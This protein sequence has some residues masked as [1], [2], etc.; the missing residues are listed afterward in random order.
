MEPERPGYTRAVDVWAVGCVAVVLLTGGLA[1]CDPVT[2]LYSE[3]LA[4][5]CD[6]EYLRKSKEWRSTR[7]RP[8]EF[9]EKLLVLDEGARLTAE[10]ALQHS[11]FYNEVHKNDFEDLYQ[12]TIKHWQPR[13]LKSQ[14]VEFQD[15]GSIRELDCSQA[16]LAPR[17]RSSGRAQMPVEP[18]YKPFARQMHQ[19]LWPPRSPTKGLSEEVLSAM[20][21]TSPASAIRLRTRAES[22]SPSPRQPASPSTETETTRPS[23]DARAASE[24]PTSTF[25]LQARLRPSAKSPSFLKPTTSAGRKS[26]QQTRQISEEKEVVARPPTP[27]P[28]KLILIE[29]P[30]APTESSLLH[31]DAIHG[32]AEQPPAAIANET[33]THHPA[34]YYS[35]P[36][37]LRNLENSS[38]Y[39]AFCEGEM[40]SMTSRETV[41][42]QSNSK[43]KRRSVTSLTPPAFKK[44]RSSSV[45]E[46]ADD[47][48]TEEQPGER[49]PGRRSI[50]E[51]SDDTHENAARLP[52]L[53]LSHRPKAS[54]VSTPRLLPSNLYLPR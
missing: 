6:L 18:P 43:L 46:L 50:F 54:P 17:K 4:R 39:A 26:Q 1:F 45:F 31:A 48:D 30:R 40:D 38:T 36:N 14:L 28:P 7:P 29:Q 37:V 44:R 3:K 2:N 24:P 21:K 20:E 41:T 8:K 27:K 11:W 42:P 35:T 51:L 49:K 12:R 33:G 22:T 15:S 10:E 9:V 16:F 34:H 47:I 13:I 25:A 19:N 32:A 5:N 53:P 52:R 23:R